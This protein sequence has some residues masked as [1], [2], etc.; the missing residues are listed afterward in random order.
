VLSF[1]DGHDDFAT[2]AV[3]VL[4]NDGFTATSFVVPGFL[5]HS[6]Y[7][8]SA[9]VQAV[10]GEG[11]T[12]GAHTMHHVD[13]TRVPPAVARYEIAESR[14]QLQQLTGQPVLD[15]AYPYGASNTSV[16]SKVAAAG[17]RDAVSTTYGVRQFLSQR[18]A[19]HRIEV[20]G[21]DSLSSFARKAMV[22][23]PAPTPSAAPPPAAVLYSLD[24]AAGGG[25]RGRPPAVPPCSATC[26][27]PRLS[28]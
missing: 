14:R 9:Q 17:F 13:L 22:P 23:Y 3:P 19:L 6:G 8:T 24:R 10:G 11:M 28:L 16:V 21:Y 27:A 25:P 15:F 1:D 20:S 7:M 26:S 18:Y 4:L 2:Q 5:G 12:I